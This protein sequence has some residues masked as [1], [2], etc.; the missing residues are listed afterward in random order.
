MDMLSRHLVH[1]E[2]THTLRYVFST[3]LSLCSRQ[4]DAEYH[5][6]EFWSAVIGLLNFLSTKVDSLVTTGGLEE[7]LREVGPQNSQLPVCFP[8]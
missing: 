2:G 8:S 3:V 6:R 7:L 4:L 5:W 1:S